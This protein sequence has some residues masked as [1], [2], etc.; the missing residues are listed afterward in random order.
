[1]D[2]Q[3]HKTT[4]GMALILCSIV[5]EQLDYITAKKGHI[6]KL[7]KQYAALCFK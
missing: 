6:D 7:H 3:T 1:M 5:P 2:E 4:K